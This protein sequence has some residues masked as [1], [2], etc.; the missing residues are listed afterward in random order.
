[1]ATVHITTEAS[2]EQLLHSVANL[3]ADELEQFVAKVLAIRA[4]LKAPS[5][6]AQEAQLL[7]E[8][9]KGLSDEQQQR[10]QTLDAKRQAESLDA[11]EHTELLEL[12][13]KMETLNAARMQH[14]VQLA[15][16]RNVSLDELMSDLGLT[17]T[18]H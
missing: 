4:N 14:L 5:L 3:P 13:E 10:F 6:P 8:I 11:A 2:T 15:Q 1:M 12:I 9:N 18:R 16:L 17:H 7:L